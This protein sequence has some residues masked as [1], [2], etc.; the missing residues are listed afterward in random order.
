LE[1]EVL[2]ANGLEN[3]ED[4]KRV[5]SALQPPTP[6]ANKM[7]PTVRDHPAW[8]VNSKTAAMAPLTRTQLTGF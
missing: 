8:R 6:T 7:K 3:G 1:F 4:W 2:E 5:V